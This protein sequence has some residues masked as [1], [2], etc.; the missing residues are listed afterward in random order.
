MATPHEDP[1]VS[2]VFRRLPGRRVVDPLQPASR[3]LAFQGTHRRVRSCRP[4]LSA[5]AQVRGVPQAQRRLGS[6]GMSPI[7]F[8]IYSCFQTIVLR[9]SLFSVLT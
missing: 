8:D 2:G 9:D 7:S 1:V 3:V 6:N 5:D 4:P